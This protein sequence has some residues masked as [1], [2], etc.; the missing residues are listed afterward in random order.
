MGYYD[1]YNA[2]LSVSSP[3]PRDRNVDI[4]KRAMTS[5]FKANPSYYQVQITTAS[6]PLSS[7]PV[8]SWITDDPNKVFEVK[9]IKLIPKIKLNYGDLVYWVNDGVGDYWLTTTVDFMG[10][11]YYRG[12]MQKCLSS[13]KW[14][15]STLTTKEAYFTVTKDS[16]RGLGIVDGK[17]VVTPKEQRFI[18]I[19]NNADTSK[20]VKGQRFIFDNGR[21]WWVTSLSNLKTGLIGLELEEQELN[22]TLDNVSLRICNYVV[23]TTPSIIYAGLLYIV[24]PTSPLN[25]IKENQSKT[26]QGVI[27]SS[28]VNVTWIVFAL[29]K[30]SATNLVSIASNTSTSCVLKANNAD[31]YGSIQLK[32]TLVSD[33][34]QYY[35][36]QIDVIGLI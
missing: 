23:P 2:I 20:I 12:S 36:Q 31:L 30:V 16:Q 32:A 6:T 15:D 4:S 33:P 7:T 8:D 3:T 29:D 26:Y 19:Q 21:A 25:Q 22:T 18:V 27:N 1:A 13:I 10:D 17:V 14:Q 5:T 24:S 9:Q 35:W 28:P 34:S 11:M